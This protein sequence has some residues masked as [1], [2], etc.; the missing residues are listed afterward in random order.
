MRGRREVDSAGSHDD[1]TCR[2]ETAENDD[3]FRE[4]DDI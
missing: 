1:D 2:Q 4:K 3:I